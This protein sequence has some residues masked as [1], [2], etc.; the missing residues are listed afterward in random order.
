MIVPYAPAGGTDIIM[1]SLAQKMGES[2]GQSFVVENRPGANGI[3][4]TDLVAKSTP[5]GYTLLISTNALTTNPWLYSKIPFHAERDLAPISIAGYGNNVLAVHNSL[6]VKTVKALIALA[7][8]R[9]GQLVIAASGAGQPSHLS[10]ELFK[11]MAGVNLVTV[12]YKGTGAALAD[13]AGGHV[14]VAFNSMAGLQPLLQS[15]KLRALG[16]S[17]PKR[18]AAMPHIPAVAET[19]PG[20]DVT[21]WYGVLAPARTP[22][23]V[24]SRLHAEML[25]ALGHDDVRQRLV[26]Q[27]FEAAGN[28]PAEFEA[29]IRADLARWQKVIRDGNIRV[30]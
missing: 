15:G 16:V 28:T 5:D 25:K 22:R 24:I 13:L 11:Q 9:P 3:I 30:E 17:G 26:A 8:A 7:K 14:M 20:F 10:G 18:L 29:V 4:G 19:L 2:T 12:Q 27:G 21:V 23:E 1:R 6:P